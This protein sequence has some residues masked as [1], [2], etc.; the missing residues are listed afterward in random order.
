MFS[1]VI[2]RETLIGRREGLDEKKK[3][4]IVDDDEGIRTSLALVFEEQGYETDTAASGRDA[5][6]KAQLK[7]FNVALV[8]VRLLDGEGTALA[9]S[10]M[11]LHPDMATIVITG[12]ATTETAIR[13]L[14]EGVSAYVTKPLEMDEVLI[15]VRRALEKQHLAIENRRLYQPHRSS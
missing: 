8:D 9:S 15:L 14:N 2:N 10:L 13:A 7:F 6:K 3:V 11:E 12:Y 1:Y 4:L 5:L